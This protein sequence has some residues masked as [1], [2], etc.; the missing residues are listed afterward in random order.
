MVDRTTTRPGDEALADPAL[1]QL[2]L[3]TQ[4]MLKCAEG[5]DWGQVETLDK[6]RLQLLKGESG[7]TAVDDSTGPVFNDTPSA[8]VGDLTAELISTDAR[9]LSVARAH[10][11]RLAGEGSRLQAQHNARVRYADAQRLR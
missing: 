11:D 9:M 4:R 8:T 3:L 7:A 1:R 5:E 6:E 2:L 10:R